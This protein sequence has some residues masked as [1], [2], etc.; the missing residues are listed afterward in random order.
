MTKSCFSSS[1][2]LLLCT[3]RKTKPTQEAAL[4]TQEK[5]QNKNLL[6]ALFL[7]VNVVKRSQIEKYEKLTRIF[8]ICTQIHS[9]L[10][11][12]KF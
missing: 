7:F 4:R 3:E 5:K 6:L 8:Q 2:I 1:P 12:K 9:F 10:L 11:C